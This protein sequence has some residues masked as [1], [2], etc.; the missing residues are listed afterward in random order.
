MF[1]GERRVCEG[2]MVLGS[3]LLQ[4]LFHTFSCV[5]SHDEDVL[6]LFSQH[7]AG[8]ADVLCR[9]CFKTFRLSRPSPPAGGDGAA[10]VTDADLVCPRSTPRSLYLL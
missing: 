3:D 7:V 1:E 10:G 8:I 5:C 4:L 2:E 6:H 9:L